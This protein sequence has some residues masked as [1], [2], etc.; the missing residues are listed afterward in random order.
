M[1]EIVKV[2]MIYF[3]TTESE[4][5]T[6]HSLLRIFYK[7]NPYAAVDSFD[8]FKTRWI[9]NWINLINSKAG[10]ILLLEKQGKIVGFIGFYIAECSLDG[11]KAAE[12]AFWY[13][14]EAHRGQGIKLFRKAEDVMKSLG[15]E[16]IVMVHMS[17]SMPEKLKK[18]YEKFGYGEMETRYV[19]RI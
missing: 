11:T 16:A 15:C 6:V 8:S 5:E 14:D 3:A 9:K 19:K 13:V 18:V 4:L 1:Q 10:K 2:G 12:E 7:A 17:H